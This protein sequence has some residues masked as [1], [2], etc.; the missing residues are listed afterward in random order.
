MGADPGIFYNAGDE[1]MIAKYAEL[2]GQALAL[3]TSYEKTI[4]QPCCGVGAL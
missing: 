4:E 2:V 1:W 3:L